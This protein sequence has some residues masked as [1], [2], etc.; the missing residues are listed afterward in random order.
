M[1]ICW[2]PPPAYT[3]APITQYH[4]KLTT[5]S[6]GEGDETNTT[7]SAELGTCAAMGNGSVPPLTTG[8]MFAVSLAAEN[9][10]GVSE[11]TPTSMIVNVHKGTFVYAHFYDLL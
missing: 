3:V 8:G 5:S 6:G 10:M 1:L 9:V 11:Y 2:T 7:L 4:L